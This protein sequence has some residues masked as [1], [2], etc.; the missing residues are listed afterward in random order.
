MVDRTAVIPIIA[1]AVAAGL[2]G[3]RVSTPALVA[4]CRTIPGLE[5]MSD[6]EIGRIMAEAGFERR[7]WREHGERVRGYVTG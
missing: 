3:D 2:G 5:Q 7:Q 1:R 6:V 4:A